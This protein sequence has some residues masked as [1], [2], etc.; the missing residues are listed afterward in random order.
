MS[1]R[2]TWLEYQP[3]KLSV[4]GGYSVDFPPSSRMLYNPDD[5]VIALEVPEAVRRSIAAQLPP[6]GLELRRIEYAMIVDWQ[7][8]RETMNFWHPMKPGNG[9]RLI[10]GPAG[11]LFFYQP[12]G[13]PLFSKGYTLRDVSRGAMDSDRAV[14]QFHGYRHEH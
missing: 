11:D 4:A 7:G 12:Q 2:E 5:H 9:V 1:A 10:V 13:R 14:W 8:K 3:H 6:D